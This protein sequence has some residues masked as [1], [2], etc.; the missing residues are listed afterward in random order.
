MSIASVQRCD[1]DF[2]LNNKV[3]RQY[4]LVFDR[5]S[6]KGY[7]NSSIIPVKNRREIELFLLCLGEEA[8]VFMDE[9]SR[10]MYPEV[11]KWLFGRT[12]PEVLRDL[13]WTCREED[14]VIALI[15]RIPLPEVLSENSMLIHWKEFQPKP[16]NREY[17]HKIHKENVIISHPYQC[18]NM[19]YF[20]GFKTSSEF[21]ID[22][23]SDHLEGII[24]FEAARQAGIASIHLAGIPL[25]G[26]IVLTKS[27]IRYKKFMDRSMP[28][29]IQV[30]PA[31]KQ[32]GGNSF[33][34]Y[35]IIQ[36]DASRVTGY[37]TGMVY[38]TK[39]SY[40]G[41]RNLNF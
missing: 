20:I 37:F 26:R 36:K 3:N 7:S 21:N 24:I 40:L 33:G 8:G 13:N 25:S 19:F 27:V 41:F 10:G 35:N 14:E 6:F 4:I 18:G 15:E 1:N 38:N 9:Q 39:K 2:V 5:C 30:I 32:R 22:H 12:Y 23:F 11:W 28:Y 29:I 34:V 16:I 31:I 17:V